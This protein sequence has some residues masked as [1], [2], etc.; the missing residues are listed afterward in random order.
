MSAAASRSTAQTGP[1]GGPLLQRAR[2]GSKAAAPC[3][4]C[5]EQDDEALRVQGKAV[6][7]TPGA[8]APGAAILADMR[9]ALALAPAAPTAAQQAGIARAGLGGD[10]DTRTA[11]SCSAASAEELR[12]VREAT[13]QFGL[14]SR[15]TAYYPASFS[16]LPAGVDGFSNPGHCSSG[17]RA[18]LRG[19][20]VMGNSSGTA[21]CAHELGHVAL[22]Q[23]HHAGS[24]LMNPSSGPVDAALDDPQCTRLCNNV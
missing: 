13:R 5:A 24:N 16:G 17:P 8:Q 15:A 3:T 4:A 12:M 6:A 1:A 14:A 23:G 2:C 20:V 10:T 7:G 21:V 19:T 11:D 18:A 22:N 9:A